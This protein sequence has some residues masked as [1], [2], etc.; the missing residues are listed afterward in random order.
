M[1]P[2]STAYSQFSGKASILIVPFLIYSLIAQSGRVPIISGAVVFLLV[3]FGI[4]DNL[5][6]QLYN[7]NM[8]KTPQQIQ[9]QIFKKMSAERKI[10]LTSSFWHFA[11]E[12]SGKRIY[13]NMDGIRKH[14]KE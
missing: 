4:S 7:V 5:D 10:R 11:K 2:S 8:K 9:D 13:H 14:I 3:F 1:V 6:F 12:M